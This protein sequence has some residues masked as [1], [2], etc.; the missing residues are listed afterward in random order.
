[1]RHK[2]S[3]TCQNDHGLD[4]DRVAGPEQSAH[5]LDGGQTLSSIRRAA[6][7]SDQ[8]PQQRVGRRGGGR[9]R[10]GVGDIWKGHVM[11]HHKGRKHDTNAL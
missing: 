7:P 1:M 3:P 9:R 8:I 11:D 6:G 5:P 2:S 10:G 4:H